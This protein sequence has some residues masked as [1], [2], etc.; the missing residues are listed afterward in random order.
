MS[1]GPANIA[2]K[3]TDVAKLRPD[4]PAIYFPEGRSPDGKRIYSHYTYAEL[5]RESDRIAAGLE[6]VG[7]GRGIR[8]VLMVRPSLEFFALTFGIFKAG[9]VPVMVDPGLGR[10]NVK[11]CLVESEPEAFIGIPV[12]HAARLALG[13]GRPTLRRMVTV[14][15]RWFWGGHTLEDVRRLGEAAGPYSMPATQPEDTAAILFTSGSTGPPKGVVYQHRHFLAQVDSIRQHYGIEQGEVDLPTFPLFALFDPALG[16]TTVIP[17]MDP[18]QPAHVD[19]KLIFEAI[20]D[21]GVTNMFGSPALLRTVGRY[22]AAHGTRLPTL[23]RIISSGAPV[24]ADVMEP[25]LTMLEPDAAIHPSYGASECLPVTSI[26]SHE[27]LNE[28]RH[29]TDQG[30]GICVGRPVEGMDVHIIRIT[31]T[32]IER[33]SQ[34]EELPTGEIGEICV[35]GPV[36]TE[37][38][39]RREESTAL[40][41][42]EDEEGGLFHRMG[43]VGNLDAQGRL[44]FCGRKGHRVE[45]AAGVL[46]SVPCEN[47]FNPHAAVARTA[48]VG[49]RVGGQT[50]PLLCVELEAEHRGTDPEVLMQELRALGAGVAHTRGIDRFMIHSGF[51]VDIRH[52]A[53]IGREALGRW[54]QGRL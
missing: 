41:K 38:Y 26:S 25:F 10:K 30:A 7:I 24:R 5:D 19:P 28:T 16:M 37:S 15:R 35:R 42:I 54:A 9:A 32:P 45:T 47:V 2:A 36:V 34:A 14:G 23:R 52:N 22:G 20:E 4:V 49:V 21:F 51:P 3:L 1:E 31:D 40:A 12:A 11:N 48:L 53:K 39:Y 17:D 8:T 46:F 33:W 27:V 13:W 18:T 44:W 43:D 29:M 50:V 6:A